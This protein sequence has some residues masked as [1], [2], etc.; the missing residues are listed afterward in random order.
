MPNKAVKKVDIA[1]D[2]AIVDLKSKERAGASFKVSKIAE[3]FES[4]K[5][6]FSKFDH[7]DPALQSLAEKLSQSVMPK[8]SEIQQSQEP[9]ELVKVKFAKLCNW[10]RVETF[11]MSLSGIR[12]K[13]L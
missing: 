10:L 7:L 12:M 3:D 2:D 13:I 6:S 1:S 9:K 5:I 11:L 4:D 8:S